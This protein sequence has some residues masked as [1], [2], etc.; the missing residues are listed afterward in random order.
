MTG[1]QGVCGHTGSSGRG[2]WPS[3]F[4]TAGRVVGA[5]AQTAA[6]RLRMSAWVWRLARKRKR[7]VANMA[8]ASPAMTRE[9]PLMNEQHTHCSRQGHAAGAAAVV[10]RRAASFNDAAIRF[11][12]TTS[13]PSTAPLGYRDKGRPALASHVERQTFFHCSDRTGFFRSVCRVHGPMTQDG[14]RRCQMH[15]IVSSDSVQL[16]R[17]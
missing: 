3:R 4:C 13:R 11:N 8:W 7:G 10:A 15:L 14:A 12:R 5:G 16:E 17:P 9:A 1:S 6:V 2:G